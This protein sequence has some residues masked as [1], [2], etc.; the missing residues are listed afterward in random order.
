MLKKANIISDYFQ[1]L[2]LL[3]L[4][5][6]F[7]FTC[8]IYAKVSENYI[9]QED[10]LPVIPDSIVSDTMR[11]KFLNKT[12]YDLIPGRNDLAIKYADSAL[13]LSENSEWPAGKG[14]ALNNLGQAL[15][16]SGNLADAMRKHQKALEI[17][18]KTEDEKNRIITFSNLGVVF[19]LL[20][21]YPEGLQSFQKSLAHYEKLDDAEQV[22]KHCSY[23]GVLYGSMKENRNALKFFERSYALYR[24][25]DDSLN[26]AIQLGNS[27]LTYE[28][29]KNY[30]KALEYYQKAVKIFKLTDDLYN[31]SIFMGNIG[32]IYAK[33]NSYKKAEE[34][35]LEALKIAEDIGDNLGVAYQKGTLGEIYFLAGK[36]SAESDR[37]TR[38]KFLKRSEK[39]LLVACNQ[40]KEIQSRDD[41]KKFRYILS[42]LYSELR[43]YDKALKNYKTARELQ[44]SVYSIRNKEIIAGL[45][46][47]R[48]LDLRDKEIEILNKNVE[49]DAYLK[50]SLVIFSF[51]LLIITGGS[52]F[53]YRKTRRDNKVLKANI[54]KRKKVEKELKASRD[55]LE[56]Y[57]DHLENLV[58]ARTEKLEIE[59]E[60]RKKTEAALSDAKEK[61]ESSSR[62]KTTFLANMSHELRTPLVGILGYSSILSKEIQTEEYKE[63]AEGINRTGKRLLDTLGMVLDLSRIES[64]K[65]EINIVKID[66][67]DML[68]Q[69]YYDFSGM[70][71]V[72]KINFSTHPPEESMILYSDEIMLKTIL[73]N[74][75]N[76]AIKFTHEGFVRVTAFK[77]QAEEFIFEIADSG[78]GIA[79]KDIKTIFEEFKQLS[80]GTTKEFPGTGLGLS[81]T[82]KFAGLLG[83]EL[84]VQSKPGEGTI[85]RII[86]CKGNGA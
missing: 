16:Y 36:D 44:D 58:R 79:E 7:F 57:K 81:I 52:I 49:F 10:S 55:E 28:E 29:G 47:R 74:L 17:F 27:G 40:F 86:F 31:Y 67:A 60:E 23:M 53:F 24:E 25:L 34:Y 68:K 22:A 61:A 83:A 75:V 19:T 33:L 11:I 39:F 59:I 12:A 76:N 78:I 85:F 5:T 56:K 66:A 21:R 64:D 15:R 8:P 20:S 38:M 32:Y 69:I 73:E 80:E 13:T 46:I 42:D 1:P 63:M 2:L 77:S 54:N 65:Y 30:L 70:A 35:V 6:P 37:A 14:E 26:F 45:E 72:K 71:S 62:A 4:L 3:C 43:Q 9:A 48:E 51:L 82:K 84:E 41:E 50:T 18:T